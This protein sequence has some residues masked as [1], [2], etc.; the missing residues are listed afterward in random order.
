M[1][2]V[3]QAPMMTWYTGSNGVVDEQATELLLARDQQVCVVGYSKT[4]M[5]EEMRLLFEKHDLP[6]ID[7]QEEDVPP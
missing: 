1:V 3:Y 4:D 2:A 6:F 7:A 5:S